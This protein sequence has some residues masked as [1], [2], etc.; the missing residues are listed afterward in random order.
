MSELLGA[1][2]LA[3]ASAKFLIYLGSLAAA[4]ALLF[5]AAH[6]GQRLPTPLRWR[7]AAVAWAFV[8]L[9]GGALHV[10][11][12]AGRLLD[13]GVNGMTDPEILAL[14]M[15]TPLGT[16]T[17]TR[18]VGLVLLILA[19][20]RTRASLA[21]TVGGVLVVAA[22]FGLSGHATH[23]ATGLVPVLVA[24]HWLV[25]AYWFGA[26]RPL[27][28]LAGRSAAAA[29]GPA[30]GFGRVA[31]FIVP[32]LPLIGVVVAWR[33]A[34]GFE[35]LLTS[36]YGA[37]LLFK[38]LVVALVLG[39]GALNRLRFVPALAAGEEGAAGAFRQSLRLEQALFVLAVAVTAV[40]TSSFSLPADA[41]HA[42]VPAASGTAPEHAAHS[43]PRSSEEASGAS[44]AGPAFTA[45]ARG[46]PEDGPTAQ[47]TPGASLL[48]ASMKRRADVAVSPRG[49]A[50]YLDHC[51]AC[52][53]V[54]LEGQPHWQRPRADG[55]LPAPPHDDSGHTWHHDDRMLF[56][57]TKLGGQAV[58]AG[59]GI[60]NFRSG[61]P[62]FADRLSDAEIR[63]V[64]GYI[65]SQWSERNR[66]I[67]LERTRA[68]EAMDAGAESR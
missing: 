26:F 35:P 15:D 59:A 14:V 2:P 31:V 23:D 43:Q 20:L 32:L 54:D 46:S 47:G 9:S 8:A 39:L 17:L 34:G 1:W 4:G 37:L 29:S 67:Q 40:L 62:G 63:A 22:S 68:R 45:D 66:R 60:D 61:M 33:L 38:V 55:T 65:K 42:A 44:D 12:T 21:L 13:D 30:E 51:A 58:M 3:E 6:G 16:A 5:R 11:V 36:D 7:P 27:T 24:V 49:R 19:C 25:A 52:H 28:R 56:E 10:A 57:Y 50:L 53:G 64:L 48:G 18:S 41:E